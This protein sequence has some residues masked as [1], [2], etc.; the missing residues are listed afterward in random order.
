MDSRSDL[1]SF[2]VVLYETATGT[3]PFRGEITGVVLDSILNRPLSLP[4]DTRSC[5]SGCRQE[6]VPLRRPLEGIKTTA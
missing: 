4:C 1:F 2:G 3:L 6:I 5:N